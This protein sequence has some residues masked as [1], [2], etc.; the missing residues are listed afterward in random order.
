MIQRQPRAVEAVIAAAIYIGSD[1]P[2]A[3][4]RFIVAAEATFVRL[5]DMPGIGRPLEL[6]NQLLAG[7]RTWPVAGFQTSASIPLRMPTS[8]LL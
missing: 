5:Y 7:V 2:D 3:A 6:S 1:S 8:L 4:D